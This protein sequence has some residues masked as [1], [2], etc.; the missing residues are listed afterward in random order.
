MILQNDTVVL[1]KPLQIKQINSI[2]IDRDFLK[3]ELSLTIKK[4]SYQDSLLTVKD[5]QIENYELVIQNYDQSLQNMQLV[6]ND[7]EQVIKE[8]NKKIL[9]KSLLYGGSGIVLGVLIGFLV[10]K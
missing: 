2:I 1:L 4:S 8:K 3:K 5:L 10:K 9:K 6:V 7:Q